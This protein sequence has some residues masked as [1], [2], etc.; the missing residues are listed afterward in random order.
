[1]GGKQELIK[2]IKETTNLD[3][4]DPNYY[5]NDKNLKALEIYDWWKVERENDLSK[6]DEFLDELYGD[7]TKI[8]FVDDG[9][10]KRIDFS[11]LDK[12]LNDQLIKLEEKVKED[13]TK[14]LHMLVDIRDSLW[15]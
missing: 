8:K 5:T 2:Y 14:Y 9:F 12:N 10:V 3:K 6:V 1:M 15:T 4:N 7:K 11:E 13:E